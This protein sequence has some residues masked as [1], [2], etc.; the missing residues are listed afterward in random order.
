MIAHGIDL[1]SDAIRDFC[2]K[3]K[4]KELS[5]FGSILRDDFRTDSDVDLLFEL[6]EGVQLTMDSW[7][8]MEKELQVLFAHKV[9]LV[10]RKSLERSSN[11]I[12]RDHIL[13]TA[14]PLFVTR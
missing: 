13:K 4:I 6:E 11:Y 3:W 7:L 12:R 2:R 9:D 8:S 14:E 10:P 1:N 5:V